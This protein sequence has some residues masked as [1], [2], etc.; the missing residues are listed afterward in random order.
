MRNESQQI[1]YRKINKCSPKLF[2]Q[3]SNF[4]LVHGNIQL[5]GIINE[6]TI[7]SP[8]YIFGALVID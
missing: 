4:I 6:E 1:F 8:L 2:F 7:F 3:G 5:P